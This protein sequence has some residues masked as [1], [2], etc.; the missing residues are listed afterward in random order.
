MCL[1]ILSQINGTTHVV[2][3]ETGH[4]K[5]SKGKKSNFDDLLPLS[6][7]SFSPMPGY[8]QK[9]N[10]RLAIKKNKLYSVQQ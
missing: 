10:L 8:R 1:L 3:A 5:I 6:Q 7:L 4:P 9:D 2:E